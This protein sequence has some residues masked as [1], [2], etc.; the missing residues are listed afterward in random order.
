MK[1]RPKVIRRRQRD[2]CKSHKPLQEIPFDLVIEIFFFL[3]KIFTRLPTKSLIRFKSVS[4]LWSSFICS[5]Y[6]TNL[7]SSPRIYMWLC[8]NYKNKLLSSSSSSPELDVSTMSSFVVDQDLTIPAVVGYGVS[9]SHVYR[10]LMCFTNGTNAQIY[11]TTTRQLVV[12]P[13]IEESN[14]AEN[15]VSKNF[16]YRIGHDTVHD[17]YKVVC[18]VSAH[19]ELEHWVFIL[20][21][22]VSSRWRK[23]SSP[24]LHHITL[25]NKD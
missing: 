23:I 8:F 24:C 14:I 12:L 4:K 16:M 1:R 7:S 22:G 6:F 3:L 20:R 10:G 9:V 11:N 13:D 17:Q 5:K 25:K 2:I 15:V 21:E 18:I 19:K